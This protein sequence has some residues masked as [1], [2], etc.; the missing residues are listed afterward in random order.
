MYDI[1]EKDDKTLD[2]PK[3]VP[4]EIYDLEDSE[5]TAEQYKEKFGED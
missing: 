4:E 3:D 5:E 2:L 1:D